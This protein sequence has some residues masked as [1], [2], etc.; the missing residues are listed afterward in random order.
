M[1]RLAAAFAFSALLAV[2]AHAEPTYKLDKA[3]TRVVSLSGLS[4]GGDPCHPFTMTGRVTE[5]NFSGARVTG[6]AIAGKDGSRSYI[7]VEPIDLGNAGNMLAV[8]WIN[9]GLQKMLRRGSRV[10]IRAYA[11]GAAG[12][13]LMLDGVRLR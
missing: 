1:H 6:F 2:A 11:C 4:S 13:V 5:Q 3:Q 7:N 9:D 10:T 8:G 12:R